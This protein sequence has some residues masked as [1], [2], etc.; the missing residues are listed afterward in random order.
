M[1]RLRDLIKVDSVL[2][3][4]IEKKYAPVLNELRL[5]QR[6]RPK[7]QRTKERYILYS[8]VLHTPQDFTKEG[9]YLHKKL[10]RKLNL[11]IFINYIHLIVLNL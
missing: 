10:T 7:D 1:T 6:V 3:N 8:V 5:S 4:S 2:H 9:G 11:I